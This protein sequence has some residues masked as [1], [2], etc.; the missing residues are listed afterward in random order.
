MAIISTMNTTSSTVPYAQ[1][2]KCD[3]YHKDYGGCL[4]CE[5]YCDKVAEQRETTS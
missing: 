4:G 5:V 1:V 2:N 3:L